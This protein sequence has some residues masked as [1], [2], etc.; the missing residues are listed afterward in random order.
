[1]HMEQI[2]LRVCHWL[3]PRIFQRFAARNPARM[4]IVHPVNQRRTFETNRI[5]F[6]ARTFQVEH[7]SIEPPEGGTTSLECCRRVGSAF[8][9]L[10]FARRSPVLLVELLGTA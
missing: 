2:P 5:A 7:A 6:T 9:G 3:L 4:R 8:L 10:R 1:M